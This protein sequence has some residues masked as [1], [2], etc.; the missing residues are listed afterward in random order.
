MYSRIKCHQEPFGSI[1]PWLKVHPGRRTEPTDSSSDPLAVKHLATFAPAAASRV[2][3]RSI[4]AETGVAEAATIL[5]S[6]A[7]VVAGPDACRI[8]D[9]RATAGAAPVLGPLVA[10]LG[11]ALKTGPWSNMD[12][13]TMAAFGPFVAATELAMSTLDTASMVATTTML[14]AADRPT[15]GHRPCTEAAASIQRSL[16]AV[17]RV[18][19]EQR[20]AQAEP[21]SGALDSCRWALLASAVL[22]PGRDW[23]G[24]AADRLASSSAEELAVGNSW[25]DLIALSLVYP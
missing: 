2:G 8:G 5:G 1:I 11:L 18:I 23:A 17:G 19:A 3:A 22:G 21:A 12:F 14:A 4:A 15:S 24:I 6:L 10:R 16:M 25:R 20:S 13:A 9:S 7:A